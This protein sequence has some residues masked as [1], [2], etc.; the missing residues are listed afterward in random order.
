[1]IASGPGCTILQFPI[2]PRIA[3]RSRRWLL[4]AVA[5]IALAAALSAAALPI[6]GR[7]LAD[8]TPPLLLD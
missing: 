1:M 8:G 7:D 2:Q 4:A 5:A 3:R 6:D